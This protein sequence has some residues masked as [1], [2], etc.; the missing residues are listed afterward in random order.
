MIDALRKFYDRYKD[1]QKKLIDE[2]VIKSPE[3][4]TKYSKELS[5]VEEGGVIYEKYLK[6]KEDIEELKALD[7]P[8]LLDEV[9]SEISEKEKEIEVLE[10]DAQRIIQDLDPESNRNAI[11]EIR[12]GV[13]GQ[14]SAIFAGDMFRMYLKYAE[15]H[16]L[17]AEILDSHETELG[18]FKEVIFSVSGKGTYQ[19][20][21]YESGVHRVQRVPETEASGRIHTSTVTVAVLPEAT[22]VD[23]Q[24]SSEDLRIDTFRSSGAG[25]QHVNRTESAVRI[26]HLPTGIAVVCESERSQI[27]NR[28]IA[29]KILRSRLFDIKKLE[30][31]QKMSKMRKK[32]IGM[33]ERSEKIRTYNFPQ[34]RITD[35][36]SSFTTHR[37]E[38][39]MNG[40]LDEMI[41]SLKAWEIETTF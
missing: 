6:I 30:E 27:Q 20:F 29:M 31:D 26:T 2:E 11:I 14:E 4:V 12:A 37:I 40:D 38:E 13:G 32:Q 1:L 25:G 8:E 18:G 7:S 35:H 3:L 28:V 15:R 23:V 33:A 17:K 19:L 41:E 16:N 24:I 5:E 22:D 10:I 21:K 34:S 9:L 39:F 36:R